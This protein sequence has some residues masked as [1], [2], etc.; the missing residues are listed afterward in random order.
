M[1]TSDP[2]VHSFIVKIWIEASA[3]GEGR[4]A[5][6]GHIVHVPSGG[7]RYLKELDDI[8]DFVM[9][10]LEEM[11]ADFAPRFRIRRWLKGRLRHFH[12]GQ[13]FF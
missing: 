4:A 1:E 13:K 10:Y 6:R 11:N 5:W 3:T 7:R 9:P 2:S 8:S 12:D